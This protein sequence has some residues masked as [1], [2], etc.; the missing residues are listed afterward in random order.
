[1]K[2]RFLGIL[3][4][5]AKEEE[6]L[7]Q[8]DDSTDVEQALKKVARYYGEDFWKTLFEGGVSRN[9]LIMV[10]EKNVSADQGLKTILKDGDLL[11]IVPVAGGG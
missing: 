6:R 5:L 1:M 4:F 3:R 11:T 10:N 9:Y 2:V 7:L 8:T